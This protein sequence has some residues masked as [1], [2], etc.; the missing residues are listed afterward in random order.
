M[1]MLHTI[2]K[3]FEICIDTDIEV[4]HFVSIFTSRVFRLALE[5]T[6]SFNKYFLL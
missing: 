5:T 4:D 2:A 1:T 3:Q 6:F